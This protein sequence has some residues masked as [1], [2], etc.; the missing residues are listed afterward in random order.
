MSATAQLSDPEL[1]LF[2]ELVYRECGMH[3]DERRMHYLQDRL[4]RRLRARQM[5]TFYGYY[6]LVTSREGR[7]EL[8]LL[9]ETLT[10]NETS[11]FRNRPQLEMF[12]NTILEELLKRKAAA[13]DFNIRIWSA[14]CSTGQEPYTIAMLVCDAL[15]FYNLRNGAPVLPPGPRKLLPWPWNVEIVASDMSYSALSG[16]EAGVYTLSQMEP[17]D[18][19]FRI[20]YFDR[21]G[22]SYHVKDELKELVHFDFHN[23]KTEFL[24]RGNDVIFCRNV[25]IYFDAA[26]QERLI[27]KL[28]RCTNPGGYLF[29]GPAETLLGTA[30][31]FRM[32]QQRNS[33]VYQRA[34]AE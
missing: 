19:S 14:G 29:I 18:Y 10:V 6:Q 7:D 4:Q 33:T 8:A 30:S 13:K 20:R 22:E 32:L 25:M 34:E 3:F 26:E 27:D 9:L 1:K 12:Q 21:K 17:V 15:A 31:K 16:G 23:L 5:S 24:P 28:Y 11:F 2:Q